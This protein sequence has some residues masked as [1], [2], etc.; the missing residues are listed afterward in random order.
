MLT[1]MLI[2]RATPY[3]LFRAIRQVTVIMYNL[4]HILGN[5]SD[6]GF[7][8]TMCLGCSN[9]SMNF[10]I[11]VSGNLWYILVIS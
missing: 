5:H 6:T 1:N 9:S 7:G 11:Y 10:D 4:Q 8:G 2:I 3:V